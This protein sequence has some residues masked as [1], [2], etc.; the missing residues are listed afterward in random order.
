M[1]VSQEAVGKVM[2][3][4]TTHLTGRTVESVV[5][6]RTA[7]RMIRRGGILSDAQVAMALESSAS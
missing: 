1:G 5:S 3:A 7:G 2:Q 4:C 6:R